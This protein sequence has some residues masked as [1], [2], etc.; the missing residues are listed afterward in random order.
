MFYFFFGRLTWI[1]RAWYIIIRPSN[2]TVERLIRHFSANEYEDSYGE[3]KRHEKNILENS[4]IKWLNN[5]F[6]ITSNLIYR[7][8]QI[9]LAFIYYFL[10]FGI[11]GN[12]DIITIQYKQWFLSSKLLFSNKVK[13]GSW[14][15]V[16]FK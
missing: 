15:K 14:V 13:G 8:W 11:D 1:S 16:E 3:R 9:L 6:F 4:H 10:Y 7:N 2:I 12:N 5:H